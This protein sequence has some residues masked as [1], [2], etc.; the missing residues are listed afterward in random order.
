MGFA[1]PGDSFSG[2][3]PCFPLLGFTLLISSWGTIFPLL[4]FYYYYTFLG[5]YMDPETEIPDDKRAPPL[6]GGQSIKIG[7][8]WN[9]K[10]G[11]RSP[12]LCEILINTKP[13]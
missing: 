2:L 10:H 13:K 7:G 6:E 8:M 4:G 12:R 11:I 1:I 5:N 9:L 3:P